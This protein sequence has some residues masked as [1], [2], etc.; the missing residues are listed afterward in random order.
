M[1]SHVKIIH[2][3]IFTEGPRLNDTS[4]HTWPFE[5]GELQLLVVLSG[6]LNIFRTIIS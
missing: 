4:N 5:Y 6:F 3:C 2:M 1:T